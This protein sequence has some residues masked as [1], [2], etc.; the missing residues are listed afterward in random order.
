[1]ASGGNTGWW[2]QTKSAVVPWSVATAAVLAA[3]VFGV[4]SGIE[5][6]ELQSHHLPVDSKGPNWAE[7]MTAVSTF[8]LAVAAFWALRSINEAKRLGSL[9][10]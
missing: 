4:T 2:S 8:L 7:I 9:Y 10:K 6:L 5:S 1:V 3:I